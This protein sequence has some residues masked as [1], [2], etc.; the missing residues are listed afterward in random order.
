MKNY[1]S[2]IVLELLKFVVSSLWP[3]VR[4]DC[5]SILLDWDY[6]NGMWVDFDCS[7]AM[8]FVCNKQGLFCVIENTSLEKKTEKKLF[9]IRKLSM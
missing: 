9:C 2:V 4:G 5:Y 7:A 1:H 3:G 8:A 6:G